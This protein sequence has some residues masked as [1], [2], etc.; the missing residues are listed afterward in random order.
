L[1]NLK[2]KA[3]GEETEIKI[4]SEND[5]ILFPKKDGTS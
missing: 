5:Q 4:D 3:T 2:D 1:D